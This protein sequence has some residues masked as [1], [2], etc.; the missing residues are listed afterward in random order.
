MLKNEKSLELNISLDADVGSID[1]GAIDGHVDIGGPGII[2]PFNI[3][4]VVGLEVG[5]EGAVSSEGSFPFNA[6]VTLVVDSGSDAVVF[7]DLLGDGDLLAIGRGGQTDISVSHVVVDFDLLGISRCGE[8]DI[9][10]VVVV[11]NNNIPGVVHK[12]EARSDSD[13]GAIGIQALGGLDAAD[14][15]VVASTGNNVDRKVILVVVGIDLDVGAAHVLWVHISA[16]SNS[17]SG[18]IGAGLS[19]DLA[20][21]RGNIRGWASGG[22]DSVGNV[23][24]LVVGAA[25][26]S[27]SWVK[28]IESIKVSITDR[29]LI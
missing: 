13:A 14:G 19:P 10:G 9:S 12:V 1:V 23:H 28:S 8:L 15:E 2:L 16:S 26:P 21:K 4:A 29:D 20:G 3:K 17:P 11:G 5:S 18:D 6:E 27:E 24:V 7:V 25:L 22:F